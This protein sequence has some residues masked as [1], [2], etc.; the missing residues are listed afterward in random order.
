[1]KDRIKHLERTV[2]DLMNANASHGVLTSSDVMREHQNVGPLPTQLVSS[3]V[4][5]SSYGNI[6]TQCDMTMLDYNPATAGQMEINK[7]E[8]T[9]VGASHW[10][11]ILNDVGFSRLCVVSCSALI[12]AIS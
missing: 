1:M 4:D 5:V 2:I 7:N 11:A 3:H 10:A 8:T 9:Y 12:G 6:K